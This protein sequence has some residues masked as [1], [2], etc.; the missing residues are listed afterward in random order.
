M[1][2][3]MRLIR[4]DHVSLDVR[5]R[6]RSIAWYE[7][8]LGMYAHGGPGPRDEPVFLGPAGSRFGLFEERPAGLKH[9]ALATDEAGQRRVRERLEQLAIPYRPERHRDHDS[10]YFRDPDGTTLEVMAAT[11]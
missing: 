10:L 6:V 4:I 9:I 2:A 1:L 8:V 5:D 11:A 3:T 7:E